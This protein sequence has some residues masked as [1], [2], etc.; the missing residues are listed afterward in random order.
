MVHLSHRIK[1]L[2]SNKT[3]LLQTKSKSTSFYFSIEAAI[4]IMELEDKFDVQI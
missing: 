2:L 1:S 3:P 4:D